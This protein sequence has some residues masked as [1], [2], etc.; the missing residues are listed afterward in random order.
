M[1]ILWMALS[2]LLS[3]ET[4]TLNKIE[5]NATTI[6]N[7]Q[8]PYTF[9]TIQNKLFFQQTAPGSYSPSINGLQ[10]DLIGIELEDVKI[11][12]S[13]FR[14][15][16]NQYFSWV[17]KEFVNYNVKNGSS[18][19]MTIDSD[20]SATDSVTFEYSGYDNSK[21]WYASKKYDTTS[22]G[23]KYQTT[24]NYNNIE[25]TSYNQKAFFLKNETLNNEFTALFSTSDDIDRLDKF[26]QNKIYTF[27]DQDYLFLNNKYTW[28][29]KD[30]IGLNYQLFHEKINDNNTIINSAN[31]I[32]GVNYSHYFDNGFDIHIN[33]SLED[34]EYSNK[35]YK[36]NTL[37][38]GVGYLS[39]FGTTEVKS[40]LDYVIADSSSSILKNHFSTWNYNL[41]LSNGIIYGSYKY[42]FKLPTANN[43]YYANTT[44]RGTDTA[45]PDLVA[46]TSSTYTIGIKEQGLVSYDLNVFFAQLQNSIDSVKIS[47]GVYQTQNTGDGI[48]KGFNGTLT[49]NGLIKSTLNA[50]YVYGVTDK[51]Y[52]SKIIPFKVYLKNEFS[53]FFCTW[54]YARE[55]TNMSISDKSDIRIIDHNNGYNTIDVGY[56]NRY[57]NWEYTLSINN[58]T[59][60]DG[61]VYGSSVDVPNR[62]LSAKL[63]YLF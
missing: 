34:L 13:T 24:G 58:I 31:N 6:I 14:S 23:V 42:G 61:R 41:E 60:N 19:G 8:Y 52:M 63:S 2:T 30:F 32:Y 16:P 9:E 27:L 49:Y 15:G 4:I 28:N 33:N 50:Q 26:Q 48:M 39:N 62:S 20:I 21:N 40:N 47:N 1:T 11:N 44:G 35:T 53:H 18:I 37:T 51:D 54:N 55:S 29:H 59:D 5:V 43:L 57:H 46:Q 12:N 17:P 56:N 7:E 38:S 10:G 3:A 22:V 25:H 36:F 45:N